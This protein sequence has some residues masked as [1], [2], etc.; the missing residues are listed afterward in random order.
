MELARRAM[1]V[2]ALAVVSFIE[3]SVFPIPPDVIM[4]PMIIAAH[5]AWLIAG[6]CTVS[7]VWRAFGYWIGAELLDSVGRPVLEFYGKADYF[8]E[9]AERFMPWSA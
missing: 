4:T 8:D 7:S 3:S 9:F 2:L 1:A 6:V 5:R